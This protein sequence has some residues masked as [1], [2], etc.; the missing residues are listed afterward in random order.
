MQQNIH[1]VQ[2]H[3][4]YLDDKD[5]LNLAQFGVYEADEVAVVRS[6]VRPGDTVLDIGANIGYYS[7]IF[8]QLVG[9][10]GKVYAFEPDPSNFALLCQNIALNGYS[11]IEPINKAVNNHNGLI[12]LHLCDDN[13]GMHRVYSSVCCGEEQVTVESVCLDDFFAEFK[14][15]IDFIK[16]DI[17]GAEYTA[18][19]GMQQLLLR[20]PN[21]K[22]LTE[23]SPGALCEYGIEPQDFI[24][25]LLKYHFKLQWVTSSLVDI[26]LAQLKQE[27]PIISTVTKQ[28]L[29]EMKIQNRHCSIPELG[30]ELMNRLQN[31]GYHRPLTENVLA[32]RD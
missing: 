22:L 9:E 17:E 15:N 21:I 31:A 27:L 28:L 4:M 13:R 12:T 19:Q 30:E 20:Y 29:T 26:N 16:M 5:S 1:L 7:L 2:G 11:N 32:C 14:G 23:F 6:H 10:K 18:I 25:L 24:D 8:A 3:K